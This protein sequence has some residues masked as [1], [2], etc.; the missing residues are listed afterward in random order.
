MRHYAA[1]FIQ[2]QS[3]VSSIEYA[4]LGSLIA[5]V[6]VVS[7]TMAGNTIGNLY[8]YIKNELLRAVP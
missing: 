3:A 5:A 6:I 7:V 1:R 2:D 8:E 4:L